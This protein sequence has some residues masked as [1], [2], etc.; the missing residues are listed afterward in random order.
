MACAAYIRLTAPP[1]GGGRLERVAK[2]PPRA[3]ASLMKHSEY[4]RTLAEICNDD[5]SS[6]Q[7]NGTVDV[8][9]PTLRHKGS[10]LAVQKILGGT[11]NDEND[12]IGDT[13]SEDKATLYVDVM[14]AGDF[15][16]H[17]PL[18]THAAT[19][20]ALHVLAVPEPAG[21]YAAFG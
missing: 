19:Q 1:P 5:D 14:A 11:T 13:P 10:F 16:G 17:L 2:L 6:G 12:Q 4:A 3:S 15:L 8:H 7:N 9:V 20:L 18:Q 21:L